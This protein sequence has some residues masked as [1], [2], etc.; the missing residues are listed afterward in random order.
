MRQARP[1]PKRLKRGCTMRKTI[2]KR[3]VDALKPGQIIADDQLPGFVC[4]RL[5]SG[6]LSYGLRFTKD[7]RRRWLGIGVGIAPEA[8][9]KAAARHAGSVAKDENPVTEREAR[10]RKTLAAR[11]LNDILDAFVRERVKGLRTEGE[12]TSLLDRFVRPELGS[13]PIDAI[14]RLE[15]VELLDG[16]A[17][18]KSPRTADK[19]LSVLGTAFKWHATRDD[20][21]RSP[22]VS[23]M[24]R[25]SLKEL[26]RD[27][28][29]SDDEIRSLW[30]ALDTCQP[31]AYSRIV[32]ALLLSACRLNEVAGMQWPEI[33]DGVAAVPAERVKTKTEHVVPIT[34]ALAD[35]I[36]KQ[37][38]GEG[39]FVF[40][41][42]GGFSP[43][44]G[45]SKAK[46]RLDETIGRQRK[47]AG[48]KP[49]APWRL[50]DLRRTARSL[51]SRAGV[52]SDIA[53][54]VLGHVMPGVRGVY[55]RYAY[56]D[57]KR[58][59][60]ERLAGLLESI[61]NPP[62]GNVVPLRASR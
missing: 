62:A 58:D 16:I 31:E 49:M 59:A 57:E 27:R 18:D 41:T 54:R 2:T 7:G 14:K 55:D 20:E 34:P 13:R 10:R 60:L 9:R 12:L 50:H 6:R 46:R 56:L 40:S 37:G 35:L 48:L 15:V 53:E 61:I 4:R 29:L 39:D 5:P 38:D 17:A 45:F 36:G 24:A 22:I 42:D 21:F 44:S 19:V 52:S 43:F 33:V 47:D 1:S 11:T 25:L 28:I 8:A 32:R 26:S 51:M 23:G 30:L 3:A